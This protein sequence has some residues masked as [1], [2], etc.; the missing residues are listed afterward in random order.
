[1]LT[2]GFLAVLVILACAAG[3]G[4]GIQTEEG[5][6]LT[7]TAAWL[8]RYETWGASKSLG[9]KV[10]AF[11][12]GAGNFLQAIGI[13]AGI[14]VAI[15]GVLVASFAGTTM[16]TA[17]RLQRYVIQEL[18][19]VLSSPEK[20][21]DGLSTAK[22]LQG[23]LAWLGN[24]HGATSVAVVTAAI[25][26]AAPMPGAEWSLDSAGKG[27]LI[28]WPLFGATNQLLAGLSFLVITFYLWR[29]NKPV[30]FTIIPMIFML[31]MPLW[32][33]VVQ[34]FFGSGGPSWWDN[35]NGLLITIALATI[36]LEIWMIWEAVL[37]FP[38]VKGVME[39]TASDATPPP[40]I[41]AVES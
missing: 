7:G 27:G 34:L 18:A 24:K 2:E 5:G 29:R 30:W 40:P 16:D 31:I 13:P 35:G 9:A 39:N 32:A 1:M 10:G 37:L 25:M 8:D 14:A 26:A 21:A 12:D 4:L 19:A 41:A 6:T 11:V 20:A 3:L 15:M 36:A 22:K 17:C 28:L 23:P 33:L 38:K